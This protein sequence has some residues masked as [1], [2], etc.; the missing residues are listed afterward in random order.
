MSNVDTKLKNFRNSDD[1]LQLQ[2][3]DNFKELIYKMDEK[4]GETVNL[5]YDNNIEYLEN[6][7]NESGAD[8]SLNIPFGRLENNMDDQQ[9]A[10]LIDHELDTDAEN[11]LETEIEKHIAEIKSAYKF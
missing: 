1:M 10:L 6:K 2:T 5:K 4:L 3:L 9:E 11:R 7:H 8:I